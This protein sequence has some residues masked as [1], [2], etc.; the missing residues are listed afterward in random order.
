M[1]ELSVEAQ[2]VNEIEALLLTVPQNTQEAELVN[3]E[4]LD[5]FGLPLENKNPSMKFWLRI[6]FDKKFDGPILKDFEKVPHKAYAE[7]MLNPSYL[8]RSMRVPSP[9]TASSQKQQLLGIAYPVK[10]GPTQEMRVNETNPAHSLHFY[11]RPLEGIETITTVVALREAVVSSA[12]SLVIGLTATT[13]S[14]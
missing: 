1:G 3:R 7:P 13:N 12:G 4:L 5:I 6:P 11:I 14:V 2:M 9:F 10:S 8:M